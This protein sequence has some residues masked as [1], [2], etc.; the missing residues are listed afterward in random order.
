MTRL[1]FFT[2]NSTKGTIIRLSAQ[3]GFEIRSSDIQRGA[4]YVN[5]LCKWKREE[6]ENGSYY[7]SGRVE[8][9]SI[10]FCSRKGDWT[11]E[12]FSASGVRPIDKNNKLKRMQANS[13][14]GAKLVSWLTCIHGNYPAIARADQWPDEYCLDLFIFSGLLHLISIN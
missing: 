1:D 10:Y 5:T 6:E 9:C 4:N 11:N 13:Q 14:L 8:M 3:P 2:T 7:A 12:H